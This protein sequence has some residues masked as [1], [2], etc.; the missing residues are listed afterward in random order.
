ME[1]ID[2]K[3]I[4]F[5]EGLKGASSEK[6]EVIKQNKCG[7]FWKN[8]KKDTY[9]GEPSFNTVMKGTPEE[10]TRRTCMLGKKYDQNS[11]IVAHHDKMAKG[12]GVYTLD[13][14]PAKVR[15][16][17]KPAIAQHFLDAGVGGAFGFFYESRFKF[18]AFGKDDMIIVKSATKKLP[19]DFEPKLTFTP[20][21]TKYI[22]Q[23][24]YDTIINAKG[25]KSSDSVISEVFIMGIGPKKENR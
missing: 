16:D 14:S 21:V 24:E 10:V 8:L 18:V 12:S 15:T 22:E 4:N 25:I 2:G 11:V 9:E 19:K 23:T 6:I 3:M 1:K 20:A 7:G 13:L 17:I 5:A